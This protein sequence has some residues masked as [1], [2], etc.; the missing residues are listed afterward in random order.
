MTG[1]EWLVVAAGI[2]AIAWVNWYF[3]FAERHAPSAAGRQG[4]SEAE[5]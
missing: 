4:E 2:A 3:F 1:S 5:R